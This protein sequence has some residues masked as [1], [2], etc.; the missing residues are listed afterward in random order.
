MKIEFGETIDIT[1]QLRNLGPGTLIYNVGISGVF[2]HIRIDLGE[3]DMLGRSHKN[4]FLDRSFPFKFR[5]GIFKRCYD[6]IHDL[7]YVGLPSQ[8]HEYYHK[9]L[10]LLDELGM[11]VSQPKL[12]SS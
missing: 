7:I 5:H 1:L 12:V 9:L 8:I 2:R 4:I 6:A 3:I 10:S 11:E